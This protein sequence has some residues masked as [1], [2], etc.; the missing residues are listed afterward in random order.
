MKQQEIKNRAQDITGKNDS[1]NKQETG[2]AYVA[3]QPNAQENVG[4]LPQGQR[5]I[6][7]W[8]EGKPEAR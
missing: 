4:F 7:S 8:V 6:R 1:K 2:T 5:I 3:Q